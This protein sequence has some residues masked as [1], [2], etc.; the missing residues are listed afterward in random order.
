[1]WI[2]HSAN[3]GR[4]AN[5]ALVLVHRLRRWPNINATL[6]SLPQQVWHTSWRVAPLDNRQSPAVYDVIMT[7][8][9]RKQTAA[10]SVVNGGRYKGFHCAACEV[11]RYGKHLPHPLWGSSGQDSAGGVE[12]RGF[13]NNCP[14]SRQMPSAWC[15]ASLNRAL[16]HF[17]QNHQCWCCDKLIVLPT[18]FAIASHFYRA[19]IWK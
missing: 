13:N 1:M 2:T 16:N 5:V 12:R 18:C 15:W 4:C 11:N 19:L 10:E 3:T 6:A 8:R 7:S 17:S 9:R 14:Q